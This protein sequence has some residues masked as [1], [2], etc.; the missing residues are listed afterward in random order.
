ME[1]LLPKATRVY[2]RLL[3]DD[4]IPMRPDE[5]YATAL[6]RYTLEQRMKKLIKINKKI[7]GSD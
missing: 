5:D 4:L 6:H 3:G 7:K 1:P 2:S